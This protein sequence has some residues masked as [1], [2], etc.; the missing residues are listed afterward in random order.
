MDAEGPAPSGRLGGLGA[1]PSLLLARRRQQLAFGPRK[2]LRWALASRPVTAAIAWAVVE[3]AA[4]DRGRATALVWTD[5]SGRCPWWMAG[6]AALGAVEESWNRLDAG[7]SLDHR[8]GRP[9]AW[10]C[11][12]AGATAFAVTKRRGFEPHKTLGLTGVALLLA[13]TRRNSG[14]PPDVCR[15]LDYLGRVTARAGDGP[16]P[17]SRR[18]WGRAGVA[19]PPVLT[20]K[21]RTSSSALACC[22]CGD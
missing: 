10:R 12:A 14:G 15:D 20:R 11:F 4:Q 21:R 13:G 17:T 19:A 9:S 3:L 2:P 7:K 6:G 16:F 5:R 22:G 8:S 1:S 18:R